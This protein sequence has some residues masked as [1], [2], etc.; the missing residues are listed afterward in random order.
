MQSGQFSLGNWGR[1]IK[2]DLFRAWLAGIGFWPLVDL[3]SYS[4][5]APRFIPL[6][7]NVCSLV[8]NIYLSIV[9]NRRAKAA[10]A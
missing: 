9:A 10:M 1:K 3:V 6:F 7:V 5:I 8:W 4:L 2:S